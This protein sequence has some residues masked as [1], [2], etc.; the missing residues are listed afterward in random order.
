MRKHRKGTENAKWEKSSFKDSLV[1][2]CVLCAFAVFSLQVSAADISKTDQDFFDKKIRP[3]FVERCY[4]C[5]SHQSEKLRGG[6]LL[7]SRDALR[8][9]GNTGP[10]IVPGNADK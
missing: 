2:L 6:L 8:K 9:G 10:A 4:Q 5:H 7:D 1:R 3:I